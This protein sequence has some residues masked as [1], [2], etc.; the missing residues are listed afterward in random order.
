MMPLSVFTKNILPILVKER[1]DQTMML[2]YNVISSYER[3]FRAACI[4]R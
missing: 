2:L 3:E 4:H 1:I